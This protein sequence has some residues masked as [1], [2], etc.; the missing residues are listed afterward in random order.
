[1]TEVLY[2][3]QESPQPRLIRQAVDVLRKGGL[4]AYPT[5]TTYALGCSIGEK[6]AL[7]R[8]IRLRR[9]D[10]K[11]QFT[12]L[13]ED[14]S[15]L[16]IYAKVANPDYRLLKAHTPGAY[17]FILNGTTEVPR[18][19]MDPKKRTIGIRVPDHA[20][21]QA[22]LAEHGQPIMTSTCHLPDD[23][24]PLTDPQDVRDFLQGQVDLV[25]DGGFGGVQ[26]TTVISLVDGEGPQVIR[27]GA[28]PIDSIF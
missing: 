24:F 12:L 4:I 25:I 14:L 1:M 19:L 9:L 8:L 15:A 2:I 7:D 22:L 28:G 3:H 23:E 26:E 6:N 18:R 13:C 21:C 17:T 11:H 5:D 27:E 10:K 20:I 16:A